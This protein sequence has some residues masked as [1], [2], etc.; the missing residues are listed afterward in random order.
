MNYP[1]GKEIKYICTKNDCNTENSFKIHWKNALVYN[2]CSKCKNEDI[3]HC[4]NGEYKPKKLSKHDVIE[5]VCPNPHCDRGVVGEVYGEK[6]YCNLCYE[7]Q[8]VL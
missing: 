6:M 2:L 5:S 7:G 8:T 4:E 1:N 3:I